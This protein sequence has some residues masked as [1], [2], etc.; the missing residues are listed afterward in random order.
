MQ[1][2][3]EF[4]SQ[5]L[6]C[7]G[8][9]FLPDNVG[10]DVKLPL[11]VMAHGFSA[12]KEQIL[13]AI[14]ERFAASGFAAVVFD[15]RFFGESDGEPRCQLLPLEQAEDY[16]NAI[17]WASRHPNVDSSRIGIWG[18]SFSGGIVAHVARVDRRVKAV[19]AQVPSIINA[20]T[21]QAGDPKK[22]EAVGKF[23]IQD[24]IDRYK[25]GVVQYMSVVA[26]DG[27]PCVLPG[28]ECY[29]AF[30]LLKDIA[31][32]WENRITVESLEKIREFDPVSLIHLISPTPLLVI[33]AE[34]DS[35]IPVEAVT[36]AFEKASGPKKLIKL[37]IGHF[38]I[39]NEDWL[40]EATAHAVEWY[41]EHL[42]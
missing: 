32:S 29:D 15:Y 1:E 39:Y 35:L 10:P 41:Q 37:P 13:P 20:E 22:W 5:R 2:S 24:R 28:K 31:P 4:V 21:R 38:E 18:T 14:A 12:V 25:T 3:I 27:E 11:I 33:A 16:R 8:W 42:R 17:S 9:L 36:R 23:L 19:V 40:P 6:T 34:N 30:A 26:P 7:R